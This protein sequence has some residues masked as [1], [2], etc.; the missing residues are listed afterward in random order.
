MVHA[1]EATRVGYTEMVLAGGSKAGLL[2]NGADAAERY[3]EDWS[4]GT[5]RRAAEVLAETEARR[6]I[7]GFRP[8]EVEPARGSWQ[9]VGSRARSRR[10]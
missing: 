8:V 9:R 10:S 6:K 1:V 4:G 7:T 2:S 5:F 3:P